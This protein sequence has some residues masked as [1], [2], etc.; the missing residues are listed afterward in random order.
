M[1][2]KAVEYQLLFILNCYI[3]KQI[4]SV[5]RVFYVIFYYT[6]EVTNNLILY[7]FFQKKFDHMI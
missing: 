3:T 7:F 1:Q 4:D 5:Y 2:N 6:S